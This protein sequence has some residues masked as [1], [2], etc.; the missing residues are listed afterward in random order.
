MYYDKK[1]YSNIFS[2]EVSILI[3][4]CKNWCKR[5]SILT[6]ACHKTGQ[7]IGGGA[8]EWKRG[9]RWEYVL[10][11]HRRKNSWLTFLFLNM[12]MR[13][14]NVSWQRVCSRLK[15]KEVTAVEFN[16]WLHYGYFFSPMC[17]EQFQ[18]LDVNFGLIQ[19]RDWICVYKV[20]KK[21]FSRN[22]RYIFQRWIFPESH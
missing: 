5:G 19:S 1:F 17:K 12:Q 10:R 20:F 11:N 2:L 3:K 15:L 16:A 13:S 8:F 14:C 21:V 7:G 18:F 4:R 22:Y 6:Q 9:V